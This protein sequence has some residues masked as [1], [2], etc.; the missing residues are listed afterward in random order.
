MIFHF[1]VAPKLF[2]QSK[3]SNRFSPGAAG[4]GERLPTW[5]KYPRT[6]KSSSISKAIKSPTAMSENQDSVLSLVT[7]IL[8]TALSSTTPLSSARWSRQS[9]YCKYT[10]SFGS[11][12]PISYP[13]PTYE[14][15]RISSTTT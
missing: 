13:C 9:I 5:I 2:R 11:S 1:D 14:R 8:L 15:W 6:S 4:S 12:L 10:L 7:L 3:G